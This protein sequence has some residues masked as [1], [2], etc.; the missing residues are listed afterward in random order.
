MSTFSQR[1]VLQQNGM[2]QGHS[3]EVLAANA[4]DR[5]LALFNHQAAINRKEDVNMTWGQVGKILGQVV[6]I[7]SAVAAAMEPISSVERSTKK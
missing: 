5:P 7:I 6:I 1:L 2:A 3:P 4:L